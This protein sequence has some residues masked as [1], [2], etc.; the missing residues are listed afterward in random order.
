MTPEEQKAWNELLAAAESVADL[1][2]KKADPD[3]HCK[4]LR[5]E[6]KQ[7]FELI[8]NAIKAVKALKEDND[9]E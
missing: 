9:G 8:D 4:P 5:R 1:L 6:Y 2:V 7:F 3:Y